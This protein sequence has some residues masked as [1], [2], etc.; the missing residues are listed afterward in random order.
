[1]PAAFR[2]IAVAVFALTSLGGCRAH[3]LQ[4]D[5]DAIRVA[6]MDMYTNQIMDNLVRAHN[7]YPFVQMQYKSITGTVGHNGSVGASMADVGSRL[8]NIS[9]GGRQSNQ[10]TV[11]ANPVVDNDAVY[12]A[13]VDF[14]RPE[15]GNF[16]STCD[17][18]P[19]GA[20]HISV[21]CG[22]MHYWVPADRKHEFLRLSLATSVMSKGGGIRIPEN[23]TTTV[24]ELS[25]PKNAKSLVLGVGKIEADKKA[26]TMKGPKKQSF[27]LK[28]RFQDY[29]PANSGT[30]TAK[31]DGQKYTF[32]LKRIVP[33]SNRLTS[34]PGAASQHAP[35]NQ[36]LFTW[37]Y[38]EATDEGEVYI[39]PAQ[40]NEALKEQTV[41]VKIDN[42][43]PGFGTTGDVLEA[44]QHEMQLFRLNQQLSQ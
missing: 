10:L 30:M 33:T 35:T 34:E 31:V 24:V 27:T 40:L 25:D 7:G 8:M 19:C 26:E 6:V 9:L 11:T 3:Q 32:N 14:V 21:C 36:F 2:V 38:G 1:M 41:L 42:H 37:T 39:S 13:Y 28:V 29:L 17:P 23:F 5:Q 20:A 12:L 15:A 43:R 44:L 4:Q 22:N 16:F 18:P